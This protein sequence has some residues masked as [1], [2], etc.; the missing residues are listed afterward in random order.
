MCVPHRFF[1]SLSPSLV[2]VR[3]SKWWRN[4]SSR[5]WGHKRKKRW[6][7]DAF[8]QR[9]LPFINGSISYIIIYFKY[10]TD[11]MRWLWAWWGGLKSPHLH[12]VELKLLFLIT[13]VFGCLCIEMSLFSLHHQ[14]QSHQCEVKSA[15]LFARVPQHKCNT[16]DK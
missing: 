3:M 4:F 7:Q 12:N 1:L 13:I 15:H 14:F 16:L 8:R 11:W 10:I 9:L 2:S 5:K 6:F